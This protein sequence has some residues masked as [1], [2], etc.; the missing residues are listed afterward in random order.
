MREF[1]IGQ[2]LMECVEMIKNNGFRYRIVA[3]EGV[4]FMLTTDYDAN[5]LNLTIEDNVIT[6]VTFG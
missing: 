4:P 1:L 5:R 6:K 3:T 2:N